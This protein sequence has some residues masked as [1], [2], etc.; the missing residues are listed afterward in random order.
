M[1]IADVTDWARGVESPAPSEPAEAIETVE[2]P[3]AP[4][5]S[6][7]WHWT[8]VGAGAA[9]ALTAIAPIVVAESQ[10]STTNPGL[11]NSSDQI[12]DLNAAAGSLIGGGLS[13]S[14]VGLVL[15]IVG[16]EDDIPPLPPAPL[17]RFEKPEV[18]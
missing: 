12:R 15:A 3:P 4:R 6:R 11:S 8:L 7:W 1:P 9:I 10:A 16:E 5:S 13:L 17:Q 18:P 14:V 2:I